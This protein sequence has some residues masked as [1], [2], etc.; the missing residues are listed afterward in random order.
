MEYSDSSAERCDTPALKLLINRSAIRKARYLRYLRREKKIQS[1]P[2][3]LN[4]E[5]HIVKEWASS[6][7]NKPN[8]VV[9]QQ[10]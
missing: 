8:Q 7:A 9:D 6:R 3:P 10:I 1:T 5:R 4:V 2:L